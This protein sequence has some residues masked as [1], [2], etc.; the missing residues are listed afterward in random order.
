MA[1]L[2][3]GIWILFFDPDFSKFKNIDMEYR[4]KQKQKEKKVISRCLWA[5]GLWG[6]CILVHN[7]LHCPNYPLQ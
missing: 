7:S 4:V 6:T 1:K 3:V 5:V 2:E